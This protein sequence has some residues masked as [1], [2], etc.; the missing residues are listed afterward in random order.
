VNNGPNVEPGRLSEV[1]GLV[2]VVAGHRDDE[3]VAVDHDFGARDTEPVD[4]GAD[5]L[6]CLSKGFTGGR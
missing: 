2:A 1:A 6:L 4:S 3:I 5:D